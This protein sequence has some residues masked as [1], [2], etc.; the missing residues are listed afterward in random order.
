[1]VLFCELCV[2][3]VSYLSTSYMS[4]TCPY[5]YF[6]CVLP[7]PVSIPL[8]GPLF[9]RAGPTLNSVLPGFHSHAKMNSPPPKETPHA[10]CEGDSQESSGEPVGSSLCSLHPSQ[11]PSK[12]QRSPQGVVCSQQ[13][14]W[15]PVPWPFV[16][17]LPS[18]QPQIFSL[19]LPHFFLFYFPRILKS[20]CIFSQF[21]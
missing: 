15:D 9:S 19:P 4:P 1:M 20:V 5:P 11:L 17:R 12:I 13:P 8:H 10:S 18:P 7:E 16:D 2:L 6:L 21:L 3:C 14:V